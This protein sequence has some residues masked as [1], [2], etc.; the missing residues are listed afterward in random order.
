MK[1]LIEEI[2]LAILSH[3]GEHLR[4]DFCQCDPAVGFVPCEYCA[5][6]QA[7]IHCR[8]FLMNIKR[9]MEKPYTI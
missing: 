5:I 7:L 2:D 8:D 6:Y 4:K 1:T 9:N 3:G